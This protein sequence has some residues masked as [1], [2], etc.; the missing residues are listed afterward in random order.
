MI[1]DQIKNSVIDHIYCTD[2]TGVKE[3]LY[4]NTSFGDHKLVML[5]TSDSVVNENSKYDDETGKP[6][7]KEFLLIGWAKWFGKQKSRVSKKCGTHTNKLF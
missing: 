2:S 3:V 5:C 1:V 4:K 6:I 7:R